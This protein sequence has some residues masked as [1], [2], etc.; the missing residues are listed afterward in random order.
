MS[1]KVKLLKN[2]N[3]RYCLGES[4]SDGNCGF[5]VKLNKTGQKFFDKRHK[6]RKPYQLAYNSSKNL[7]LKLH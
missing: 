5:F 6:E 1:K 4:V 7:Y 2:H 3:S